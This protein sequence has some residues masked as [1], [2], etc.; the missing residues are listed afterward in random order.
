M[1]RASSGTC[2]SRIACMCVK[3]DMTTPVCQP[4]FRPTTCSSVKS[5]VQ[6]EMTLRE[7]N[8]PGGKAKESRAGV[9]RTKM[10]TSS[11]ER[12]GAQ[13]KSG[14]VMGVG[15]V[16]GVIELQAALETGVWSGMTFERPVHR[17]QK[18]PKLKAHLQQAVI[19]D[20][21]LE[22]ARLQLC[23]IRA[24]PEQVPPTRV[25]LPPNKW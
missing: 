21:H 9:S 1:R 5:I 15:L 4:P 6:A 12:G 13:R 19:E 2:A 16:A 24:Q 8:R 10:K 7:E 25:A 23:G 3:P 20:G 11:T 18:C 17:Q 14:A 22:A